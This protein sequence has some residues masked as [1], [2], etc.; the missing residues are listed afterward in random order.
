LRAATARRLR[1]CAIYPLPNP[2]PPPSRTPKRANQGAAGGVLRDAARSKLVR[3]FALPS[4]LQLH[5]TRSWDG[6]TTVLSYL[7]RLLRAADP[8]ALQLRDDFRGPHL[9]AAA[10]LPLDAAR[11]EL[12]ALREALG[13]VEALLRDTAQQA[14]GAPGG[15]VLGGSGVGGGAPA[16]VEDAG[17]GADGDAARAAVTRRRVE[18]LPLFAA[19]AQAELAGLCADFTRGAADYEALACRFKAEGEAPGGAPP[20][21]EDF[22]A[23]LHDFLRTFD[24][25]FSEDAARAEK[26]DAAARRERAA[27]HR[28]RRA[29]AAAGTAA[30]RPPGGSSG[31]GSGDDGG[32]TPPHPW[33]GRPRAEAADWLG[34]AAAA[35][36]EVAAPPPPPPAAPAVARAERAPV[37]S[38]LPLPPPPAAAPGGGGGEN[39]LLAAIR[40]RKKPA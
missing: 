35:S 39:A 24:R 26:K 15:A 17:G 20:S 40:A 6:G 27:R 38:A 33:P 31:S 9:G 7:Q 16:W 32:A 1:Q 2:P 5:L 11:E 37:K 28:K 13:G 14:G 25:T 22:F 4:L 30:E 18:P 3:A 21:P 34:S 19:L 29:A 8:D 23:P 10:R 12:C 36:D